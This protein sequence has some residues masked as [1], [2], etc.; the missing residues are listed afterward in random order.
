[1]KKQIRN[2]IIGL[3]IVAALVGVL[4]VVMNLPEQQEESSST[5]S[6]STTTIKLLE[7][8]LD[9]IETIEVKNTEEYTLVREP[10]T[11]NE[12]IIEDLEG[13]PKIKNSY[14]MLALSMCSLSAQKVIAE[15]VTDLGQYGLAEPVSVVT[16]VMKDGSHHTIEIGNEA[17]G[18]N[19]YTYVKLPGESTV[20]V[21]STSDVSRMLQVRTDYISTDI[22][23]LSDEGTPSVV[24]CTLGGTSRTSEI[25]I[26]VVDAQTSSGDAYTGYSNYL[27][28][29]PSKRDTNTTVFDEVSSSVFYT[30]VS[31]IVAYHVTDEQIAEYG[32]DEPY[33]TLQ[34]TYMDGEE[35]YHLDYRAS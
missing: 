4:L 29:S 27:I 6:A 34:M 24:N 9:D 30:T 2:L 26:E 28:T 35:T 12:W 8:T 20:Y 11:D 5:A 33:S 1:M 22:F 10:N 17:P 14:A 13:L 32:L 23:T 7:L 19:N 3:V 21:V 31:E 25:K 18:G 16:A 15:D